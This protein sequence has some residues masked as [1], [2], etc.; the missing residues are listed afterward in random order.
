M[1]TVVRVSDPATI[2]NIVFTSV[3]NW[4]KES[5]EIKDAVIDYHLPSIRFNL[6]Q[7]FTIPVLIELTLLTFAKIKNPSIKSIKNHSRDA[8]TQLVLSIHLVNGTHLQDRNEPNV[9]LWTFLNQWIK[10]YLLF[11]YCKTQTITKWLKSDLLI[12][13]KRWIQGIPGYK[14][15]YAAIGQNDSN[16]NFKNEDNSVNTINL[17]ENKEDKA[18]TPDKSQSQPSM[19]SSALSPRLVPTNSINSDPKPHLTTINEFKKDSVQDKK[20]SETIL[21]GFSSKNTSDQNKN[22]IKKIISQPPDKISSKTAYKYY[23]STTSLFPIDFTRLKKIHNNDEFKKFL[24]EIKKMNVDLYADII[25]KH[26]PPIIITADDD[27]ITNVIELTVE[28]TKQI[29]AF[30]LGIE[31][32]LTTFR[33][34]VV[35]ELDNE[36]KKFEDNNQTEAP[37][38][39][40]YHRVKAMVNRIENN[41]LN[42]RQSAMNARSR[43]YKFWNY[44]LNNYCTLNNTD[45]FSIP[46]RVTLRD[47]GINPYAQPNMNNPS[48]AATISNSISTQHTKTTK[49]TPTTTTKGNI[50]ESKND[51][52]FYVSK[53]RYNIACAKFD[54]KSLEF[55]GHDIKNDFDKNKKIRHIIK[56]IDSFVDLFPMYNDTTFVSLAC[57]KIFHGEAQERYADKEKWHPQLQQISNF[58][59]LKKWLQY[60]Y[61]TH[62]THL[63]YLQAL[64]NFRWAHNIRAY[65]AFEAKLSFKK[66]ISRF[67]EAVNDNI[68]LT[69]LQKRE[70]FAKQ[71]PNYK[72]IWNNSIPNSILKRLISTPKFTPSNSCDTLDEH[73]QEYIQKMKELHQYE[74]SLQMSFPNTQTTQ[75][76]R[77]PRSSYP[78]TQAPHT[79]HAIEANY[80]QKYDKRR[81][82]RHYSY[83]N[84]RYRKH[85]QRSKNYSY[86]NDYQRRRHRNRSHGRYS[87]NSRKFSRSHSRSRSRSQSRSYSHTPNRSPRQFTDRIRYGARRSW[88]Y[89]KSPHRSK[90][91]HSSHSRDFSR[92]RFVNH[93]RHRSQSHSRKSSRSRSRCS[94][95]SSHRSNSNT[96]S[97]DPL[98]PHY[99]SHGDRRKSHKKRPPSRN[100]KCQNCGTWGHSARDCRKDKKSVN[101]IAT[102]PHETTEY[103]ADS[104]RL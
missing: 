28:Q 15:Y 58:N 33:E 36:L 22:T 30:I 29:N 102:T 76:Q 65:N 34:T 101:E 52:P 92:P 86:Y 90:S 95:K 56:Q 93:S 43:N 49:Q 42:I 66:H 70:L 81:H 37:V 40:K 1:A 103:K 27:T 62:N 55:H 88:R 89:S 51:D 7:P 24:D 50:S 23:E 17:M 87:R 80:H 91:R 16:S 68:Y 74:L 25:A 69:D 10:T 26:E 71:R 32:A 99:K 53:T 18:E 84:N 59:D 46:I 73:I 78:T 38:Y 60:N 75:T 98:R 63:I 13:E 41:A 31:H 44:V 21:S 47:A 83:H 20:D 4:E 19:V 35:N 82:R 104:K 57:A 5:D 39:L 54:N 11:K 96:P 100:K 8:Y 61:Q 72:G 64:L 6:A 2:K 94:S 45:D 67:E 9:Q 97:H 48:P 14:E 77:S 85:K 79:V 3:E 12:L